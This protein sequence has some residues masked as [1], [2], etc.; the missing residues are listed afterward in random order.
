ML[1]TGVF[2]GNPSRF[3]VPFRAKSLLRS[4]QRSL[5][6]SGEL[7]TLHYQQNDSLTLLEQ[8]EFVGL[9]LVVLRTG[10]NRFNHEG[11]SD[12]C[13]TGQT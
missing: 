10:G 12:S 9:A 8:Q 7:A 2:N 5:I 4:E 11:M 3:L 6:L 1:R 13:R